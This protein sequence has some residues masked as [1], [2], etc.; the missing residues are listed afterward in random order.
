MFQNC[1]G[2]SAAK[3]RLDG[4][5][6]T[7]LTRTDV[8]GMR[9]LAS[10]GNGLV[11][12]GSGAD[13]GVLQLLPELDKMQKGDIESR[14]SVQYDDKYMWLAWPAFVLLC[15]AGALGEGPLLKRR[16]A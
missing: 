13:L 14:L 6:H 3:K 16:A 11:L 9:E 4:E 7:V 2:A 5:N 15:A 12:R 8:A 10:R 1:H